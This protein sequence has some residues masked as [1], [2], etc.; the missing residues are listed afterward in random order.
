MT[1]VSLTACWA[2][3]VRME[4]AASP[5]PICGDGLAARFMDEEA[6][7]VFE[8]ARHLERPRISLLVRHRLIDGVVRDTL[9]L[10]PQAQIVLVGAGFD[11]RA[12]RLQGGRWLEVDTPALMERKEQLLPAASCPSPLERRALDLNAVPLSRALADR[13]TEEPCLVVIEGVL[14]YLGEAEVGALLRDLRALFPRHRLVC[15]LMNRVFLDRY[16]RELEQVF[17]RLGA[18]FLF[19]HDHPERF[20]EEQGYH[21]L[22]RQSLVGTAADLG[23]MRVPWLVRKLFLRALFNG[24]HVCVF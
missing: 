24:S 10:A 2:A 8:S 1:Q 18:P 14:M 11:T 15:D 9:A 22:S 5:N 21:L 13:R 7:Q 4:D 20:V 23:L 6:Q 19:R 3:G 12:F 16:V 17:S